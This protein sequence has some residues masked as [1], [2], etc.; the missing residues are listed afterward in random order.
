MGIKIRKQ[1]SYTMALEESSDEDYIDKEI[2]RK[3]ALKGTESVK[4]VVKECVNENEEILFR[5]KRRRKKEQEAL[6]KV[7]MEQNNAL[8]CPTL[9]EDAN[10]NIDQVDNS[11]LIF[12]VEEEN[13][14]AVVI[15]SIFK[16]Y[17][18]RKEIGEMKAFYSFNM[19]DPI[20]EEEKTECRA[21]GLRRRQD[22]YLEA[23]ANPQ[24]SPDDDTD[25]PKLRPWKKRQE[26]YQAAIQGPE[27]SEGETNCKQDWKNRQDSYMQAVDS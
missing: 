3:I 18:I 26:S 16:G 9:I 24:E 19:A 15:Q 27:S 4:S 21:S 8:N 14:A 23:I 22:S 1:D 13:K 7:I 20:Y 25:Q 11:N 2:N 12:E 6:D 5:I 17:K 10:A